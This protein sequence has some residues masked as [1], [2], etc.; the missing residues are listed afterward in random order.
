M[1]GS[2]NKV[3]AG[4]F[5]R[6]RTT[7]RAGPDSTIPEVIRRKVVSNLFAHAETIHPAGLLVKEV[8]GHSL[9]KFGS[10]QI[11]QF[12]DALAAFSRAGYNRDHAAVLFRIRRALLAFRDQAY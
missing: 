4:D 6:L 1:P 3:V 10:P 9:P 5:H 7:V 2:G 11:P 12:P 8:F